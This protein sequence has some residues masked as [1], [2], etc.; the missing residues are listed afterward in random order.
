MWN[1]I[2]HF[3]VSGNLVLGFVTVFNSLTISMLAVN[4]EKAKSN[5]YIITDIIR[6]GLQMQ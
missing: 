3:I 4:Y 1:K 2:F 6:F 5:F